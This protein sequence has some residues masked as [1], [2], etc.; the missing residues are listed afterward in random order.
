LP[1]VKSERLNNRD[2]V[3]KFSNKF[4]IKQVLGKEKK[5]AVNPPIAIKKM[6]LSAARQ[7]HGSRAALY[8]M[9]LQ[10]RSKARPWQA[11]Q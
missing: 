4:V 6:S 3:I 10:S 1:G 8:S 2:A 9:R 7:S 5:L 11:P